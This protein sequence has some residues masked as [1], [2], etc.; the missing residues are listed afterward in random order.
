MSSTS[1]IPDA[2][3]LSI[4]SVD[5]GKSATRVRLY[6]G[7][8]RIA[9]AVAPPVSAIGGKDVARR[10]RE[11][12][13]HAMTR[14]HVAE[15]VDVAVFGLTT[16]PAEAV[17]R[18][19]LLDEL[20]TIVPARSLVV[21]DDVVLA[22]AGLLGGPGVVLCAG[23]GAVA[24]SVD[25]DGLHRRVDGWGPIL[26]DHGGAYDI[27]RC[28][29]RAA[30]AALDGRGPAT[31]LE[32]M[33][34]LHLGELSIAAAQRLH[35]R[36]TVAQVAAFARS[37][38]DAADEGDGVAK[39]ICRDAGGALATTVRRVADPA[40]Q[41]HVLAWSGRLLSTNNAVRRAFLDALDLSLFS[42]EIPTTDALAGGPVLAATPS[43]YDAAVMRHDGSA[44]VVDGVSR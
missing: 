41:M 3:G 37:V 1:R 2:Q 18:H 27:G 29:L 22:H 12:V 28:G 10:T 36:D 16:C 39:D 20:A 38:L 15:P 40:T 7:A 14:L 31:R 13:A 8:D 24:L 32:R 34:E 11:V 23:T 19:E 44:R 21:G 4:L 30:L 9:D 6:R 33:A 17:E 25:A 42:F 43:I 26:G 35:S 5:G